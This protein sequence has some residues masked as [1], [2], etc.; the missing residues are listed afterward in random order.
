VG[1]GYSGRTSPGAAAIMIALS[2]QGSE[3]MIVM[4][5]NLKWLFSANNG[6]WYVDLVAFVKEE[7][8]TSYPKKTFEARKIINHKH[9]L[10]IL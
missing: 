4:D 10:H 2:R 9:S 6:M 7:N 8:S 3:Q 5:G 1:S